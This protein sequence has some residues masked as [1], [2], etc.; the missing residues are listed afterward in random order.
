VIDIVA[1]IR[2]AVGF[3]AIEWLL[4]A[5]C[6]EMHLAGRATLPASYSLWFELAHT[7]APVPLPLM[8]RGES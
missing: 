3:T 5:E 8:P 7:F 6:S 2:V 1:A 4:V